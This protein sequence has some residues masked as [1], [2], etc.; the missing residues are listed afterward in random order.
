MASWCTPLGAA[1]WPTGVGIYGQ[2]ARC[3]PLMTTGACEAI[4]GWC[5]RRL[6][7][8]FLLTLR[9]RHDVTNCLDH[10]ARFIAM[11]IVAALACND[12]H[13]V[14]RLV[15]CLPTGRSRHLPTA[16]QD[17]ERNGRP[18]AMSIQDRTKRHEVDRFI[19]CW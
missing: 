4:A 14:E 8:A 7:D 1:V 13:P 16:C 2:S 17:S 3:S 19:G 5:A 15:C 11:N 9:A 18:P 12:V 10:E 6:L